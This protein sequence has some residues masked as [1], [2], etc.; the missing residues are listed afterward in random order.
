[1]RA[2]IAGPGRE[3]RVR[4][5]RREPS[6]TALGVILLVIL[7]GLLAGA[8]GCGSPAEGG[9]VRVGYLS[10]DLHQLA[11]YVAREK[12]FFAEEGVTVEEARAFNAGPD[13]MSAFSAG[14]LDMGYV[15]IAPAVTFAGRGMADIRVVAQANAGGSSI[16]VRSGLDAGDVSGMEGRTVAVP[17]HSSVQDLLLR[18]AIT[19]VGLD[20]KDMNIITL[21]PPEMIAALQN[22]QI[23]GFVAW[24][25]YPQ[26]AVANGIGRVLETSDEIWEGHPCCVLV[27]SGSFLEKDPQAVEKVVRAHVKATEYIEEH[28]REAA[29]MGHL[30]TGQD[31]EV[32]R[33]AISRIDFMSRINVQGL[34]RYV[35]FL[36][37][38]EVIDVGDP[39]AFTRSLVY[40]S[41]IPGE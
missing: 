33:A 22:G 41:F 29:D 15:G 6:R 34:V 24:E 26:A 17:G 4:R 28:P 30:F 11:Y 31:S 14:E 2:R 27:A 12:G 1:L 8:S 18:L 25:P 38:L 40:D 5:Y 10:N 13:E 35:R 3:S 32:A 19:E 39:A 21:K 23:E 36:D 7:S 37:D 9:V 20:Q 16:V